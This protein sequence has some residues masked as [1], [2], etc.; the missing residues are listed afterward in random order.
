V[1]EVTTPLTWGVIEVFDFG[2]ALVDARADDG[3]HARE[4]VV[5]AT[6]EREPMLGRSARG[7][8]RGADDASLGDGG[9]RLLGSVGSSWTPSS[10]SGAEATTGRVRAAAAAIATV[11]IAA[12]LVVGGYLARGAGFGMSPALGAPS[13][14]EI[15]VRAARPHGEHNAARLGMD[16]PL[17]DECE[18]AVSDPVNWGPNEKFTETLVGLL[19]YGQMAY[20]V[21]TERCDMTIPTQLVGR[22]K[23]VDGLAVDKCLTLQDQS[24]W[25]RASLSH[26]AA[27]AH[28]KKYGYKQ[29]AILE[30]DMTAA[31][32]PHP[33]TDDDW[34]SLNAFLNREK[35]WRV[36]RMGYRPIEHEREGVVACP[37]ECQ[38]DA[39]GPTLCYMRKSE[40]ALHASD[41]Y[42]VRQQ[43]YD[44]ILGAVSV[45]GVIDYG[46]LQFIPKQLILTPQVSFQTGFT[47]ELDRTDV[48]TQ[49]ATGARFHESC[50][51]PAMRRA[52]L[53]EKTVREGR[54]SGAA[55]NAP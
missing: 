35:D 37:S 43:D 20:V 4:V 44:Y 38:C 29:V 42:I 51:A 1:L 6:T 23:M 22:I 3:A 27:I 30:E 34:Q 39:V 41:A 54:G 52:G 8:A 17:G 47:T 55:G 18:F 25:V 33:W 53:G 32:A 15:G 26:G 40:C 50:M 48:Q 45:G 21:C 9:E 13:R 11:M 5:M 12:M 31:P 2:P 36:I 46:V 28:A 10:R 24:H 7:M 14:G 16:H 49:L 19:A